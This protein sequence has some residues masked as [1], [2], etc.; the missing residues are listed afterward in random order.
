MNQTKETQGELRLSSLSV[1]EQL[2]LVEKDPSFLR[3]R[4][5]IV[6]ENGIFVRRD[7]EDDLLRSRLK[8]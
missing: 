8:G 1:G 4:F 6:T 3:E 7:E 2:F 5:L